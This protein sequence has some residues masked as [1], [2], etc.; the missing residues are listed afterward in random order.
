MSGIEEPTWVCSRMRAAPII[1]VLHPRSWRHPICSWSRCWHC[2]KVTWNQC[3]MAW[4]LYAALVPAANKG[5]CREHQPS[6]QH[7]AGTPRCCS[8]AQLYSRALMIT[9]LDRPQPALCWTEPTWGTSGSKWS[10][11][12]SPGCSEA[13]K[14]AEWSSAVKHVWVC[15]ESGGSR[16][17][18]QENNRWHKVK[19]SQRFQESQLV[20]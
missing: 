6:K 19:S 9:D 16:R 10:L 14:Q 2:T 3:W 18:R 12:A 1:A 17:G 15:S 20:F 4:A 13:Q 11:C 7:P 5:E 8:P